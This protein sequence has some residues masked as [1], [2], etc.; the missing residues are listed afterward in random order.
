MRTGYRP[1]KLK[2]GGKKTGEGWVLEQFVS[3]PG[4]RRGK[5]RE[6]LLLGKSGACS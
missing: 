6:Y 3:R 5:K 4:E 2:K 1:E